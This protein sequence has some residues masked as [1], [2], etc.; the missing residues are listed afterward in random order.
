VSVLGSG[1][2]GRLG[3]AGVGGK[4]I[5]WLCLGCKGGQLGWGH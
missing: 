4:L 1:N 2:S 3:M 5:K